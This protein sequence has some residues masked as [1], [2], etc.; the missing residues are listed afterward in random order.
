MG[1]RQHL[2]VILSI[3]NV[4]NSNM[5]CFRYKVQH[6]YGFAPNPFHG[7]LTLATCKGQIRGNLNLHIN[8][9]IVGLGSC[10]MG[11]EGHVIYAMKVEERLTFDEYWADRRFSCKKPVLNGSLVQIYGDNV[12]HHTPGVEGYI[13]EPCAHSNNDGTVNEEHLR[14]DTRC[15][16]VLIS[17]TFYYFGDAC[18]PIPEEFAYINVDYRN[19]AYTDLTDHD[20]E[21]NDF[22]EWLEE[23][24]G[25][26]I[27]GDP[28]NWREFNLP[29]ITLPNL[30]NDEEA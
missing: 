26:G 27:H 23:K 30:N 25:Q 13:Q 17:S 8:D 22:V 20:Q 3:L 4:G 2:Y 5:N 18:P 7:Y 19:Y 10:A 12:Y 14:R 15:D 29:P 21:I 16:K 9:W 24:Y 1:L 6:D 11:N 28:C